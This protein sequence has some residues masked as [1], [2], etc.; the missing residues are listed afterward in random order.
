MLGEEGRGGVL[1]VLIS[2]MCFHYHFAGDIISVF[3]T[4]LQLQKKM[5]LLEYLGAET[6]M[7]I[8]INKTKIMVFS[9]VLSAEMKMAPK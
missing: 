7:E 4:A 8:N 6:E 2:L 5:T 1:H 9:A 3:Y